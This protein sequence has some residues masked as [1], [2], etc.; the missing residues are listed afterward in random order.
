MSAEYNKPYNLKQSSHI[1]GSNRDPGKFPP[2]GVYVVA[3]E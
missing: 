3:I 1:V 2:S